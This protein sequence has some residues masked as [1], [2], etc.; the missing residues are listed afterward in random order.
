MEALGWPSE[1][2]SDIRNSVDANVYFFGHSVSVGAMYAV[3]LG[4]VAVL[5]GVYILLHFF[6]ERKKAR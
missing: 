2:L 6:R 4:S 5:L 3:L 1:V